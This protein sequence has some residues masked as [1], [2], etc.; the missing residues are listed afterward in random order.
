MTQ[1]QITTSTSQITVNGTDISSIATQALLDTQLR[2]A[3]NTYTWQYSPSTSYDCCSFPAAGVNPLTGRWEDGSYQS[4]LD[5]LNM[6]MNDI[7]A[8]LCELEIKIFE[9]RDEVDRRTRYI[10]EYIDEKRLFDLMDPKGAENE[11]TKD[12]VS[13]DS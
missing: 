10:E 2:D 13:N 3:T 8:R 7:L 4:K 12:N 9:M 11:K 6:R 5:E 1:D